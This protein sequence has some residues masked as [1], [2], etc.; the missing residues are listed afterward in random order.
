MNAPG[1]IKNNSTLNLYKVLCKCWVTLIAQG[2]CTFLRLS[3]EVFRA[4]VPNTCVLLTAQLTVLITGTC[5]AWGSFGERSL[6][7]PVQYSYQSIGNP[8]TIHVD[9]LLVLK[10]HFVLPLIFKK[11]LR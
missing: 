7:E 2:S 4:G 11:S 10:M 1:H 5:I 8:C 9:T 3:M 6:F